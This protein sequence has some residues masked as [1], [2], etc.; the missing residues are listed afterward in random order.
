MATTVPEWTVFETVSQ[1]ERAYL[2][3]LWD[4]ELSV[5]FTSPSG[6]TLHA[7]AFWDGGQTWRIRFCPDETGD[8][9]W[10][11]TCSVASDSGLHCRTGTFT[12]VAAD[13]DNPLSRHGALRVSA[14]GC[15]LEH[16]DGTPFFWLADTA[17][18]GAIRATASDWE[19]YLRA[20]RE[21]K[22]TAI[23]F[24]GTQWRGRLH[25]PAGE[26]AYED[27]DSLRVNPTW[28]Q[29]LDAKV[30]AVNAAGLVA[31]PVMLW[32]IGEDDPGLALSERSAARL[33]SYMRARWEAY[34]VVWFLGGDGNYTGEKAARWC[35]IGRAVF[36]P[37][38]GRLVTM[39][40]CGQTW[41]ADKFRDESWFDFVGYQSGH[42]DSEE[43][44]RWLV[45]G[46]PA[47][48]WRAKPQRPV[49]NLEPNYEGAAGYQHKTVFTDA[50]VRRA[51]YWSL[52][53]SPPAGVSYGNGEI[54]N[55]A[56]AVEVPDGHPSWQTARW[57]DGLD[58]PGI[59]S[60]SVLR[61]MMDSLDWPRLR[62]APEILAE[63]PGLQDPA[64]FIAVASTVEG[65]LTIA[66]TPG[67][68]TIRLT[69]LPTPAG[70]QWLDPRTG[71]STSA[72]PVE[73]SPPHRGRASNAAFEPPD[74]GDW[75]LV[76]RTTGRN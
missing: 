27:A 8:W 36:S 34:H 56:D 22:F 18:N 37:A 75:L 54:W 26:T 69:S 35:R 71:R 32:A 61:G 23:Q 16:A 76:I 19:R 47:T 42:G 31:A 64:R 12:C 2:D 6:R 49:I 45:F 50:E 10:Q 28:F 30:R 60:M 62:P 58:T 39:H 74:D 3:P 44:L 5:A 53:L 20:R 59:R 33:A 70:A 67:G 11:S 43:H 48:S 21:Q 66:Y 65:D 13:G 52:L 1:G 7:P 72:G 40:P 24:V 46:P 57:S 73:V 68:D 38:G 9:R 25:D 41:V 29:R 14:D 15:R 51:A 55:W 17:W 4:V 63:Q